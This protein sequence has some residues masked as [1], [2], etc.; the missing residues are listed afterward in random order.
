MQNQK[1]QIHPN[2][3]DVLYHISIDIH[4]TSQSTCHHKGAKISL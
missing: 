3:D 1:N 2:F 4:G